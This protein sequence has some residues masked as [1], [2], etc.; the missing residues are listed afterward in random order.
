MSARLEFLQ[1][2]P[3]DQVS[4][5]QGKSWQPRYVGFSHQHLPEPKAKGNA[6]NP[7]RQ[8]QDSRDYL[9]RGTQS[10][11][12]TSKKVFGSKTVAGCGTDK[13]D[14]ATTRRKRGEYPRCGA[15]GLILRPQE[16]ICPGKGPVCVEA[17]EPCVSIHGATSGRCARCRDKKI[18]H[19]R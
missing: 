13:T 11:V 8:S 2:G 6:R 3:V 14:K 5:V 15:D 18:N 12:E 19:L 1:E 7:E 4:T 16:S 9:Q 17:E 10:V